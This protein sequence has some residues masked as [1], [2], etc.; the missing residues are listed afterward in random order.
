MITLGL[1][2]SLTGFGWAIHN[3][4]VVGPAR[5]LA[6]GVIST[7]PK[8]LFV[9]RYRY[10]REA[11]RTLLRAYPEIQN[12]GAESPPYG[13]QQSEGLYG[14]YLFVTEAVF[15][16]RKDLVFFDPSTLK[17]L[18]RM[19]SRIRRGTIDKQDVIEAARADSTI[20]KWNHNE[21][22]AYI[23]GRSAAR[24][25]DYMAGTLLEDELTPSE[26]QAFLGKAS[27]KGIRSGG[28]LAEVGARLFKFSELS[29]SETEIPL[30][31]L[32]R[33]G[34]NHAP[35]ESSRSRDRTRG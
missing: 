1:D 35:E 18:V 6:K 23:L 16:S 2:P 10:L 17:M 33:E 13:E 19:D 14:L 21:A 8:Q 11:L 5:V 29:E 24:L 31:P 15:M 34:L 32:I 27:K 4:S 25:W 3:S 30:Y 7:T 12:V 26:A 28:V 20:K 9:Q 22:D